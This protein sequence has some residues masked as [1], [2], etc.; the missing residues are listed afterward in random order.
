MKKLHLVIAAAIAVTLAPTRATAQVRVD[1]MA[2][3]VVVWLSMIEKS[4]VGLA[5]AMP[6]DKYGFKPTNG[7]FKDVRTF[8]EQVKHVAC[9]NFAFYNEI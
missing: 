2:G 8:A 7:A 1:P 6:A 3:T 9:A 4:F 5:D